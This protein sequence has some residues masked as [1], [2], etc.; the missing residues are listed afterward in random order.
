MAFRSSSALGMLVPLIIII[1]QISSLALNTYDEKIYRRAWLLVGHI[2]LWVC[3]RCS[4]SS[5]LPPL[6]SSQLSF[7]RYMGLCVFS[8]PIS[9]IMVARVCVLYLIIIKS[10]VWQMFKVRSGSNGSHCMSIYLLMNQI[11]DTYIHTS[12][13]HEKIPAALRWRHNGHDSV[14]NHQPHD[15]LLIRLFRRRSKKTS[16]RRVTGLCAGNSPGKMFP[17]DDVIMGWSYTASQ[18]CG[19]TMLMWTFCLTTGAN[20]CQCQ[21][22]TP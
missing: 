5:G 11:A 21:C 12:M 4:Y 3:L 7:M 6:F 8:L 14:S 13:S 1:M 10:E 19:I 9:L 20:V 15:C 16:K 22:R 17:F 2:L 18:L